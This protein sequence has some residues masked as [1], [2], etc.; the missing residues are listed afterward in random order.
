MRRA[1]HRPPAG[2]G[3]QPRPADHPREARF[4][5]ARFAVPAKKVHGAFIGTDLPT[6]L[7]AMGRRPLVICGVPLA[8]SV[9][10]TVRNAAN[11]G[12]GVRLPANAC[13][14]CDKRHLTGRL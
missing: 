3:A 10:A 11:L 13:W 14:S 7:E 8:N 2:G 4:A 5:V 9:E 12:F 6:R 1:E